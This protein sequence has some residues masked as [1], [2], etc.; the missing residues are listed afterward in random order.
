MPASPRSRIAGI[1]LAAGSGTRVGNS[2]NKAYLPLG[3]RRMLAWSL[4]VVGRHPGVTRLVLVVRAEDREMAGEVVRD[5]LPRRSVDIV[6]GGT[7]RHESEFNALEF[8][9]GPIERGALDVVLIH[10]AARPL[11][12]ANVVRQVVTA[13]EREGAAIPGLVAENVLEVGD[14]DCL[15]GRTRERLVT[16]QTPQGFQARPLLEAYRAAARDGYNGTDTA[17]CVERYSDMRIHVVPGDP[18]N[19]KVTFAHDLFVAERLLEAP[20]GEGEV[21]RHGLRPHGRAGVQPLP[22]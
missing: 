13:A 18:R 15:S 10:D 19:L 2:R 3:G 7:S 17:S 5:E 9:A 14:D 16:V 12:P 21:V 20:A 8:L 4:D 11:T 6:V 22:R 1:V